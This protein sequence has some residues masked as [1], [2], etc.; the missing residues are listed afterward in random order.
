[1]FTTVTIGSEVMRQGDRDVKSRVQQRSNEAQRFTDWPNGPR[2][3]LSL[4]LM[5][6]ALVGA[7]AM[8]QA[9]EQFGFSVLGSFDLPH[10]SVSETFALL[11]LETRSASH[12][13]WRVFV[14]ADFSPR[15][16][17]WHGSN[18]DFF[19]FIDNGRLNEIMDMWAY[20]GALVSE[21]GQTPP[22]NE[23]FLYTP[24]THVALELLARWHPEN[25][26]D[27]LQKFD[28]GKESMRPRFSVI[29]GL[30]PTGYARDAQTYLVRYRGQLAVHKLFRPGCERF[31]QNNLRV[32][33][34]MGH[35]PEIVPVIDWGANWLL[36]P[37]IENTKT[38]KTISRQSGL[39]PLSVIRDL[40]SVVHKIH[41]AGLAHLD[42]HP[43]HVLLDA[44]G[45][46]HV[47]DIDR[48]YDY[49]SN[50]PP[51]HQNVMLAG[52]DENMSFDGP[53]DRWSYNN[54]WKKITGLPL[55]VFLEPTGYRVSVW[56]FRSRVHAAKR[57][58]KHALR[59]SV[60]KRA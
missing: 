57:R 36:M 4:F 41:E 37:F 43:W 12:G 40:S 45:A 27:I 9:L 53:V 47:I 50:K 34:R 19:R 10:L 28:D 44:K 55:D 1:M 32:T 51:I 33:E 38:L 7:S 11:G 23:Q 17:R 8:Q 48:I 49:G 20:F 16:V 56:R 24:T 39:L 29:R 2:G 26:S 5:P 21:S 59:R 3:A 30:A 52:Y 25:A 60:K 42:F 15:A 46:L 22:R 18:P 35:V 58:L 31:L 6:R 14:G 54:A 13:C